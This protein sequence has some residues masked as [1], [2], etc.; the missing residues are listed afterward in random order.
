MKRYRKKFVPKDPSIRRPISSPITGGIAK[1][2]GKVR[3]IPNCF[4]AFFIVYF[5][6]SKK[7]NITQVEI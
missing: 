7:A 1:T 5:L 3:K 4:I 6:I 2:K